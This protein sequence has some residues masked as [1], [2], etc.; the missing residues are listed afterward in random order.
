MEQQRSTIEVFCCYA[1]E[2]GHLL[3]ELQRQQLIT[4]WHNRDI[5][6]EQSQV[7]NPRLKRQG[8]EKWLRH[9]DYSQFYC[10]VDEVGAAMPHR[11]SCLGETAFGVLWHWIGE[12]VLVAHQVRPAQ[13][14]ARRRDALALHAPTPVHEF[15]HAHQDFLGVTPAQL[16][17]PPERGCMNWL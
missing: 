2:D 9:V 5:A 8:L 13:G 10:A 11:D 7:R 4:M 1:H 6:Q 14:L 16:A 3:K 17:G 12:G 15:S